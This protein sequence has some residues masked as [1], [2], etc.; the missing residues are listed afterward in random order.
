MSLE[1][2]G[3]EREILRTIKI[4]KLRYFRR[5]MSGNEYKIL[6]LRYSKQDRGKEIIRL[7]NLMDRLNNS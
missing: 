5:I 4:R 2:V 1:R 3:K 7:K 6:Q